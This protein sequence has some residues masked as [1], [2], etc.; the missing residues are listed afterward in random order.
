MTSPS[1]E[2]HSS[3]PSYQNS[4]KQALHLITGHERMTER[5]KAL[6]ELVART[7]LAL[8]E[9]R[10]RA[11]LNA[12]GDDTPEQI[13]QVLRAPRG[14]DRLVVVYHRGVTI[15]ALLHPSGKRDPER[16]AAVWRCL[17]DT[18]IRERGHR[19]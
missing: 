3:N 1:N 14:A 5:E 12:A 2:A 19:L 10:R 11:S 8:D 6:A 17:R 16:E 15:K 13:T 18:A 9:A 4:I 7:E